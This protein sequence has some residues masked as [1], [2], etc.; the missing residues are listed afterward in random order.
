MEKRFNLLIIIALF[1]NMSLFAQTDTLNNKGDI[2]KNSFRLGA[3]Y[4]T[5][6][7]NDQVDILYQGGYQR[8]LNRYFELDFGMAYFHH[9]EFV[10][11]NYYEPTVVKEDKTSIVTFDFMV[12]FLLIDFNKHILKLGG[13][14]SL[15]KTDLIA[16][17]GAA[18]NFEDGQYSSADYVITDIDGYSNSIIVNIEYGYRI[19][20]RFAAT[21][22]GK[23]Y[24]ENKY[25]SLASL[26]LNFYYT[27]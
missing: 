22:C 2:Y 17:R 27:F 21:V 4:S 19:F 11:P 18:Y 16:W 3:G 7:L 20:P 23:Y 10:N 15:L 26:G 8:K 6:G 9:Q 5:M 1:S 13:G 12:N 24:S 25:I 14:Y